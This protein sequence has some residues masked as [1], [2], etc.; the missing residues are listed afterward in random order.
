M[1]LLFNIQEILCICR[2]FASKQNYIN[3]LYI[4]LRTFRP[5]HEM[6]E[7]QLLRPL[8]SKREGVFYSRI[9]AICEKAEKAQQEVIEETKKIGRKEGGIK[10]YFLITLVN[11]ASQKTSRALINNHILNCYFNHWSDS[12]VGYF[13]KICQSQTKLYS[14]RFLN[15]AQTRIRFWA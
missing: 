14:Q 13:V 8:L 5:R 10:Q 15:S 3:G 1:R 6:W 2:K 9:N 11:S 12:D 7:N 4:R